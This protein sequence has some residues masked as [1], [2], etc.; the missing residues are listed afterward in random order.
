LGGI[1]QQNADAA[2]GDAAVDQR[3]DAVGNGEDFLLA[4]G[5][6]PEGNFGTSKGFG[7]RA[8]HLGDSDGGTGGESV[9]EVQLSDGEGEEAVKQK[10]R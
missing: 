6:A 4:V 2:Q 7:D 5:G 3:E 1:A 10:L 9:E 8:V